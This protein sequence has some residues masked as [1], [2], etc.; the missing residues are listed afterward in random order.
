MENLVYL[1]FEDKTDQYRRG[2][3]WNRNCTEFLLSSLNLRASLDQRGSL[4]H[5]VS[6]NETGKG[7]SSTF[8]Y[9]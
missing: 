8:I 6:E 2:S 1:N 3:I 9:F 5:Q 4:Q 7:I